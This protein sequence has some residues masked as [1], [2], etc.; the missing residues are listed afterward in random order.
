MLNEV[1]AAFP[2]EKKASSKCLKGY[3]QK[4]NPFNIVSHPPCHPSYASLVS[5]LW[6]CEGRLFVLDQLGKIKS[7]YVDKKEQQSD[8]EKEVG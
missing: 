4:K 7:K 3:G 1:K 5:C 6:H 2:E 8:H